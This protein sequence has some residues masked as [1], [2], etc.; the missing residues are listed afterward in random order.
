MPSGHPAESIR[1]MPGP[2]R[3]AIRCRRRKFEN[4]GITDTQLVENL[5]KRLQLDIDKVVHLGTSTTADYI[6]IIVEYD[7]PDHG[8]C[9]LHVLK[10]NSLKEIRCPA[11]VADYVQSRVNLWVILAKRGKREFPYRLEIFPPG[12]PN[13]PSHPDHPQNR[14]RRA[15]VEAAQ[16]TPSKMDEPSSEAV[17]A[18]GSTALANNGASEASDNTPG[19]WWM[20]QEDQ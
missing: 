11:K 2:K 15:A 4:K 19:S 12:H 5:A 20:T 9:D 14:N 8:Q 16:I 7:N 13:H 17:G 3:Y 1:S 10:G 6:H 18:T